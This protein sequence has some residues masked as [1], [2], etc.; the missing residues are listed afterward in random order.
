MAL[1][2]AGGR[3]DVPRRVTAVERSWEAPSRPS[4]WVLGEA[5]VG[6]AG[7]AVLPLAALHHAGNLQAR[8]Y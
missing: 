2:A 3:G 4:G 6:A 1:T 8:H 5:G 7:A